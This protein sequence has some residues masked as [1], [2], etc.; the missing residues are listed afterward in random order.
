MKRYCVYKHTSPKGKV[1]IG[2]TS[3]N[4]IRRWNSGYG[5]KNNTHFWS[6]IKK[7]GWDNFKHEILFTNLTKEK[8][9]TKEISLIA[10][11]KSNN[12]DYGYNLSS[13]GEAGSGVHEAHYKPVL[14]IETGII[15]KSIE[16][17]REK[18]N[19]KSYHISSCCNGK[20]HT[21][22]GFH[23]EYAKLTA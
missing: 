4:P 18:L 15:Y 14:C 10:H 2:I 8:A 5:Y 12:P 13:G 7:Y 3:Q 21:S 20:R 22:G 6:A 1:Y 19:M 23:W 11:Y 9:C 16:D 17:A